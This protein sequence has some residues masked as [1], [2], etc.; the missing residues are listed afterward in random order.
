M[1]GIRI[2]HGSKS[3]GIPCTK[4][5]LSRRFHLKLSTVSR[6]YP[7]YR[8]A[9]ST[10]SRR[11]SLPASHGLRQS[12][13]PPIIM[14]PSSLGG[15][16]ILRRTLSVCLSVRPSRYRCHGNVFSSTA[17][18]TDVL[19]GTHCVTSSHLANYNDTHVLFGEGRIS[20]GRTDS[21]YTRIHLSAL[22]VC[23]QLPHLFAFCVTSIAICCSCPTHPC[24]I[25]I[26][27]Q[28]VPSDRN[29]P[30]FMYGTSLGDEISINLQTVKLKPVF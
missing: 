6:S 2:T 4:S 20:Y 25:V 18:V 12:S 24:V 10:A 7:V 16:C 22:R 14:R 15:G 3:R 1:T 11:C 5:C 21:C 17:S 30:L 29:G 9:D 13:Q 28:H 19:F 8:L 23:C 26:Q 27:H